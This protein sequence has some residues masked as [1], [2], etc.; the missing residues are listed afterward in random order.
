MD[1][2][3]FDSRDFA[4]QDRADHYAQT[5]ARG[6]DIEL[7]GPA[8][9]A[10]VV[11]TRLDDGLIYDRRLNDVIHARDEKR[12]AQDGF[13]HFTATAVLSGS[14]EVETD[15]DFRPVPVGAI[16]ILAMFHPM[17]NRARKAHVVTL[18]VARD[19]LSQAA[20]DQVGRSGLVIEG[21]MAELLAGHLALVARTARDLDTAQAAALASATFSLLDAALDQPLRQ[22]F[23]RARGIS[24]ERLIKDFVE[25]NLGDPLLSL[26]MILAAT[27]L[28]RATVY[29][30]LESR[31]GVTAYIRRRRLRRL[32]IELADSTIA[33]EQLAIATGFASAS[34]ASRAFLAAYGIRPGEYRRKILEGTHSGIP[35]ALMDAWMEEVLPTRK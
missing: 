10:V 17:R 22:K 21:P 14:F 15:G 34:H 4:E 27:G 30:E 2:L 24:N 12:S 16:S 11:A 25:A 32:A 33:I 18:S 3:T 26:D 5:Y 8:F 9:E 28:S 6:A 31:N 1:T 19:R 7:C 35:K 23:D 13:D 20:S 29:R